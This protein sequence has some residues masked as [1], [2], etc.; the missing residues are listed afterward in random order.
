MF[1]SPNII[2]TFESRPDYNGEKLLP[3]IRD[4]TGV[5]TSGLLEDF[6]SYIE[7]NSS[8]RSKTKTTFSADRA[9]SMYGSS[10]TNQPESIRA[11]LLIRF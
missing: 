6:D 10:N 5:F 11:L 4:C 3:M 7:I 9:S 2:G 1:G 8:K